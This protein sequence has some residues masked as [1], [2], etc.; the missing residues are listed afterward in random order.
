[1]IKELPLWGKLS[2]GS[3]AAGWSML[4]RIVLMWLIYFYTTEDI[5]GEPLIPPI[6]FGLIMFGGRVV[7]AV[8]D[9]L[10]ARLSDNHTG[11]FG[12]RMPFLLAGGIIYVASFIALFYPPIAEKSLW[13]SVYLLFFLGLFFFMFTVYVC[14]YLALLPELARSIKDRV[15]LSTSKAVFT[16]L[17]SGI[18][19]GGGGYVIAMFGYH[20]MIWVM[21]II[22]L[23]FLYIPAFIKEKEYAE[24]K[25]AT[26]GLMESL[27]T[28]LKN[29]A[30]LIYLAGNV[31]L[32]FGFNILTVNMALYV[33]QIL[34]MPSEESPEAFL[35]WGTAVVAFFLV[36]FLA[37]KKG[38]KF[39]MI[40]S[41]LVFVIFLPFIYFMNEPFF[42]ISPFALW[43][44]VMGMAGV[45]IAGVLIIPDA[46][47][48]TISDMEE[49]ITGQRR[50]GMYFGAQGFVQKLNL[51][52]STVV[53]T[54]LVQIFGTTLGLQLTGPV[55]SLVILIGLIIFLR[56]P[57]DEVLSTGEV[58]F[59]ASDTGLSQ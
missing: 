53:T 43:Y 35:A 45:A 32:W 4:E 25:P 47:V 23:I 37:K 58:P 2:Y 44:I 18:A 21:G 14:P 41:M 29:R 38:L 28:T 27:K 40:F 7:D 12:R 54:G 10:V 36:N 31:G 46:I 6:I 55:A 42:G 39:S 16:L 20:G 13:N 5:Y 59:D 56:Y 8:A 9:P 1:M 51:G 49:N 11:R 34:G 19:M 52:L 22:A 24:A 33:T 15:D 17:G 3:G 50:E 48:A 26:L 57:E 30:F